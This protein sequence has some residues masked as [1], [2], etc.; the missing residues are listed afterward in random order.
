MVWSRPSIF[1]HHIGQDE[2]CYFLNCELGS[3]ALFSKTIGNNKNHN[4]DWNIFGTSCGWFQGFWNSNVIEFLLRYKNEKEYLSR[5]RTFDLS[6]TTPRNIT[7]AW[8]I[9]RFLEWDMM[10]S[11]FFHQIL[12]KFDYQ[13]QFWNLLILRIWKHP[14]RVEF[15]EVW[16]R[17]SRLKTIYNIKNLSSFQLSISNQK[18]V[19]LLFRE[20]WSFKT[21]ILREI[22][23]LTIGFLLK[24]EVWHFLETYYCI[25]LCV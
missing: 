22:H 4:S 3:D 23:R 9:S 19:N 18:T 20:G 2:S 7:T 10:F 1:S 11:F 6:I 17:Y 16:L 8:Y 24:V 14:L 12:V 25:L 15:D 13:Y 21:S 5:D